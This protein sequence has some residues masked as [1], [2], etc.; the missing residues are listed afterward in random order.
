MLSNLSSQPSAFLILVSDTIAGSFDLFPFDSRWNAQAAHG[1]N[2]DLAKGV[3][4]GLPTFPFKRASAV[5][6]N[7][8]T[9]CANLSLSLSISLTSF[10]LDS[11]NHAFHLC[12]RV[13]IS[14]IQLCACWCVS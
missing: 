13:C 11:A 8:R 5:L 14:I 9:L 12:G 7:L 6:H 2:S 3:C 10:G 4:E 1:L